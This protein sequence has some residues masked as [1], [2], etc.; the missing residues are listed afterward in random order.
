M[1][2]SKE[3]CGMF[4]WLK[5]DGKLKDMSCRVAKLRMHEDELIILPPPTHIKHPL[6]K[7]TFENL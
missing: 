3:V 5:P 4:L 6:R 2:L 1:R 7:I